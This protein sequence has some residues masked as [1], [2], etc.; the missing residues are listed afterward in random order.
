MMKKDAP[1]NSPSDDTDAPS[2]ISESSTP[3]YLAQ[4][5]ARCMMRLAILVLYSVFLYAVPSDKWSL[6]TIAHAGDGG[7]HYAALRK[8]E[9]ARSSRQKLTHS[10][11]SCN[12]G[13]CSDW[14]K[15]FSQ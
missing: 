7:I 12:G 3:I 13:A 14:L 4:R 11:G 10:P 8:S 15:P 1:L 6:S 9:L 5:W 2:H